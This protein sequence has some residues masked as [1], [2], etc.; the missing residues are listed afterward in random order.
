MAVEQDFLVFG[1]EAGANV[2]TQAEYA[3][4]PALP[5]G[6]QSGIAPSAA[7]NKAWR[8]SSIMAAVLGQLIADTTGNTVID[9]GTITTIEENLGAVI[10]G[11]G[12]VGIDSGAA[13]AYIVTTTPPIVGLSSTYGKGLRVVFFPLAANTGASTLNVDG[14][15]V[16]GIE[17]GAGPLQGGEIAPNFPVSVVW[18]GGGWMIE[19]SGGTLTIPN[20]TASNQA[21]ALGQFPFSVGAGANQS[22]GYIKFPNGIILQWGFIFTNGSS[23]GQTVTYPIAFP[24]AMLISAASDQ[25]VGMYTGALVDLSNSQGIVYGGTATNTYAPGGIGWIAVGY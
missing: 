18:T 20:A 19:K 9:D 21:V 17:S 10:R 6:F 14:L 25:G 15:G 5:T 23:S 7:L 16:F 22:P 13:N 4:L 24:H 1:G 2:L 11:L 8:Q 3:A 12:S